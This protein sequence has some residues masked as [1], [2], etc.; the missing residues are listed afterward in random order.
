MIYEAGRV[1]RGERRRGSAEGGLQ[2]GEYGAQAHWSARPAHSSSPPSL[3]L[4]AAVAFWEISVLPPP[5]FPP[6]PTSCR[7]SRLTYVLSAHVPPAHHLPAVAASAHW[8]ARPAHSSSS[9]FPSLPLTATVAFCENIRAVSPPPPPRLPT[10]CRLTYLLSTLVSP[11]R[12]LPAPYPPSLHQPIRVTI[13]VVDQLTAVAAEIVSF[14]KARNCSLPLASP[15]FPSPTLPSPSLPLTPHPSL[16]LASP[17]TPFSPLSLPF[18]CGFVCSVYPIYYLPAQEAPTLFPLPHTP[19]SFDHI[20]PTTFT[21]PFQD[22]AVVVSGAGTSGR[23][24]FQ[25]VLCFNAV[26]RRY[27][28]PPCFH[29]L[30]AGGL[31]ALLKAQEGAEDNQ[32]AAVAALRRVEARGNPW[33]KPCGRVLYIGIS[34]G[35]S[36]PYVAAQVKYALSQSHYAVAVMGFN[37]PSL[38]PNTKGAPGVTFP[39]V[40]SEMRARIE[41]AEAEGTAPRHFILS[42]AVG[43]ETVTGSTRLK[44]GTATKVLLETIFSRAFARVLRLPALGS[45]AGVPLLLINP[46]PELTPDDTTSVRRAA[47]VGWGRTE[48]A[49]AARYGDVMAAYEGAMRGVYQQLPGIV[50]LTRLFHRA[51]STGGR[52]MYIG[53]DSL[54]LVGLIDSSEKVPTFGAR[55]GS[56]LPSFQAFQSSASLALSSPLC[57]SSPLPHRRIRADPSEQ[58]PTFGARPGSFQAFPCPYLLFYA[59]EQVPT[60]GARPG[61]FQGFL[62][63]TWH[64]LIRPLNQHTV[65]PLGSSAASGSSSSSSSRRSKAGAREGTAVP[66]FAKCRCG[67]PA[68]RPRSAILALIFCSFPLSYSSLP[69]RPLSQPPLLFPYLPVPTT[70]ANDTILLLESH[71]LQPQLFPLPLLTAL[72]TRAKQGLLSLA[73]LSVGVAPHDRLLMVYDDEDGVEEGKERE[74]E[75]EGEESEVEG[76]EEEGEE[77]GREEDEE[78]EE[79]GGDQGESGAGGQGE[80]GEEGVGEGGEEGGEEDEEEEGGSSDSGVLVGRELQEERLAVA[81]EKADGASDEGIEED[82][83][84]GSEWESVDGDETE[85]VLH[86]K[87]ALNVAS[88]GAHVLLGKVYSNRMVDLRVSNEKLF[89]RAVRVVGELAGVGAE[90]AERCV[91]RAIVI[92]ER[93]EG[94]EGREGMEERAGRVKG[95][96]GDDEGVSMGRKVEE[97]VRVGAK[98]ERIVPTAILLAAGCFGDAE[99][100]RNA[101]LSNRSV[102][103]L[104]ADALNRKT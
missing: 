20:T 45:Y 78:G 70:L 41:A 21:F 81:K 52:V 93:E 42:P 91:R 62:T 58:V 82:S 90:E 53:D 72:H 84:E 22:S 83:E 24:A 23:I 26:L 98:M 35:L 69:S 16:P 7:P 43:P 73:L 66:C 96:V 104:V 31:P 60:F 74:E 68:A 36:A 44:G 101:A 40:L 25:V 13:R 10:P 64:R 39:S 86:M 5:P 54:G 19:L 32:E 34:C 33:G 4:T 8:S 29:F 77:E 85:H 76:S 63:S 71:V 89:K 3:P 103:M 57:S 55:P 48:A 88:S 75:E 51:I 2:R 6:L 59:S 99:S 38:A 94:M 18:A 97:M 47:R 92:A 50:A 65:D 87:L 27:G 80:E 49:P 15:R 100:A 102:R 9:P 37:P 79:E 12:P 1:Q 30:I 14:S 46:P 11:A 67:F 56:F 95:E 28:L 17:Y 61:S